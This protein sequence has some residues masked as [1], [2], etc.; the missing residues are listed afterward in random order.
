MVF[1]GVLMRVKHMTGVHKLVGG[2]TREF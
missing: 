2:L 1:R